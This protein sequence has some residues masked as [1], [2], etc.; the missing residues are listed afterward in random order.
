M[1]TRSKSFRSFINKILQEKQKSKHLDDFFSFFF[2]NPDDFIDNFFNVLYELFDKA[3]LSNTIK[4]LLNFFIKF[5]ENLNQREMPLDLRKKAIDRMFLTLFTFFKAPKERIRVGATHFL[6]LLSSCSIN[7]QGNLLKQCIMIVEDLQYDKSKEVRLRTVDLAASLHIYK[8]VMNIMDIDPYIH[9]R[10]KCIK[11]I[12]Y[13]YLLND[14]FQNRLKDHCSDLR[15]LALSRYEIVAKDSIP[16]SAFYTIFYLSINDTSE[17]VREKFFDFLSKSINLVGFRYFCERLDI[18]NKSVTEVLKLK[19]QSSQNDTHKLHKEMCQLASTGKTIEIYLLRLTSEVLRTLHIDIEISLETLSKL[20]HQQKNHYFNI[21]NLLLTL[22]CFDFYIENI[23][24][25]ILKIVQFLVN[26][27]KLND[28]KKLIKT[29][30]MPNEKKEGEDIIETIVLIIRD[31]YKQNNAEYSR[32]LKVFID[33]I[34]DEKNNYKNYRLKYEKNSSLRNVLKEESNILKYDIADNSHKIPEAGKKDILLKIEEIDNKINKCETKLEETKKIIYIKYYRSLVVCLNTLKYSK[35]KELDEELVGLLENLIL[36]SFAYG[37][38]N[39]KFS[40]FLCLGYYCLLSLESLK[41]NFEIFITEIE[42]NSDFEIP[43]LQFL[44]D[45]YLTFD[46]FNT[47]ECIKGI[48]LITKYFTSKDEEILKI[49]V[50]GFCK[51]LMIEKI[52]KSIGILTR[53]IIIYFSDTF[54]SIKNII[55]CF[56]ENY[57][58]ESL[59]KC[60]NLLKSLKIFYYLKKNDRRLA[61]TLNISGKN[62]KPLV[63]LFDNRCIEHETT[64]NFHF[65]LLFFLTSMV[66]NGAISQKIYEDAISELN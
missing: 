8:I 32:I 43:A 17:L 4:D 60:L 48:A 10:R 22:K 58:K 59:K 39:V 12:P 64:Q 18:E 42:S 53:L 21:Y 45:F 34:L 28:S 47:I 40:G 27:I 33:D 2:E 26:H 3:K 6:Y 1:N 25:E 30:M 36:P 29:N 35:I 52:P 57:V 49:T 41:K 11:L 46:L 51:L 66:I 37:H 24:T 23:R 44:F 5:I 63:N 15:I 14:C 31:M 62:M 16:N 9:A 19:L 56:I 7:I 50:I 54:D 61:F 65:S 13:D 38:I 55:Y 20:I